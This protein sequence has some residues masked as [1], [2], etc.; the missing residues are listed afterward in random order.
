MD[1]CSHILIT[2]MCCLKL[3][4][5][6]QGGLCS[7]GMCQHPLGQQHPLGWSMQPYTRTCALSEVLNWSGK[8]FKLIRIII[9][10]QLLAMPCSELEPGLPPSRETASSQTALPQKYLHI[11]ASG[12]WEPILTVDFPD[13][14]RDLSSL[15][16]SRLSWNIASQCWHPLGEN[17]QELGL[18][19][20][21]WQYVAYAWD[22]QWNC[23]VKSCITLK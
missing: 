21:G 18:N 12:P 19:L 2:S 6:L 9:S 14:Q 8:K 20:L 15:L 16:G 7:K 3:Q 1:T 13:L 22:N 23:W 11:S 5:T 10:R 17:K 4:T